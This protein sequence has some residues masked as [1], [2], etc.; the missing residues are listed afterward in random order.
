MRPTATSPAA[1]VT[2]TMTPQM[3]GLIAGPLGGTYSGPPEGG[4]VSSAEGDAIR[5]ALNEGCPVRNVA[6]AAATAFVQSSG[7]SGP[8]STEIPGLDDG[9][10]LEGAVGTT[11]GSDGFDV[12]AA[13]SVRIASMSTGFRALTGDSLRPEPRNLTVSLF[14]LRIRFGLGESN[15]IGSSRSALAD[16]TH[17][18]Y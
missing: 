10:A 7:P 14:E 3:C 15:S 17:R 1:V 5:T 13:I 8:Q 9:A 2:V 16:V 4:H 6:S 11:G 12:H 18:R